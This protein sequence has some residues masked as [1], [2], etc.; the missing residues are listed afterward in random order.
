VTGK[1]V[2]T[3]G[4]RE[5][6]DEVSMVVEGIAEW[7]QLQ[8]GMIEGAGEDS[9]TSDE[10]WLGWLDGCDVGTTAK[11]GKLPSPTAVGLSE[12]VEEPTLLDV[13]AKDCSDE[14]MSV[15]TK[16]EAM[17]VG[18]TLSNAAGET[19][20]D[21]LDIDTLVGNELGNVTCRLLEGVIAVGKDVGLK[22]SSFNG[23]D[24]G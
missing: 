22:V 6:S 4:V 11:C 23:C 15:G 2:K 5:L 12:T 20:G 3:D 10:L 13:G 9:T 21:L 19:E 8:E 1:S 7:S 18:A 14:R 17:A 24:G 16:E